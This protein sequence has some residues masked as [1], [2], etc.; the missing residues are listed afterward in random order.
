MRTIVV[1]LSLLLALL[2][3]PVPGLAQETPRTG[4]VLKAA[5]IGEP[6]SLDLHWTTA[7]SGTAGSPGN[8]HHSRMSVDPAQ[9]VGPLSPVARRAQ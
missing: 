9:T 3:L 5:M 8:P 1:A 4:G 2:L 7:S 6:P